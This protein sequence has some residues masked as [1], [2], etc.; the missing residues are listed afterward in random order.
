MNEQTNEHTNEKKPRRHLETVDNNRWLWVRGPSGQPKGRACG[1][2]GMCVGRNWGSRLHGM[3]K[4]L[5]IK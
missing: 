2:L 1:W 4:I 5:P 3:D